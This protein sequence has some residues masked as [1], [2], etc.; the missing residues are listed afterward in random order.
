MKYITFKNLEIFAIIVSGRFKNMFVP[1]FY[2]LFVTD[3][4]YPQKTW[5]MMRKTNPR[6]LKYFT[7]RKLNF[8]QLCFYLAWFHGK[9]FGLHSLF[10]QLTI[11]WYWWWGCRRTG[12]FSVHQQSPSS[13]QHCCILV[14]W[15]YLNILV[16]NFFFQILQD[17]Q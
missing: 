4:L 7:I 12:L 9:R 8:K 14:H 5:Q 15:D 3:S 2:W 10:P 1:Q 13:L 6:F 11:K 16:A 17:S